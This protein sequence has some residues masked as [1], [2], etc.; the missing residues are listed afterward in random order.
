MCLSG[1]V[2]ERQG[3]LEVNN[4]IYAGVF[5]LAWVDNQLAQL[6]PDER[7]LINWVATD[8]RAPTYLPP[9]RIGGD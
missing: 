3:N 8:Y 2:V 7:T 5:N 1:L 9:E 6:R 4:P